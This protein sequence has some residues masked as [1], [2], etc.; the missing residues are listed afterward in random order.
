MN[1]GPTLAVG[2]TGAD[3][4]RLQR[5][6][7]MTKL[8]EYTG[9]DGGFGP[10]TELAVKSFQ[11]ANGLT[12]D[13]VVGPLT[14]RALPADPDTPELGRGATGA[15]VSALQRAL[16]RYGGSGSTTDPG[17]IDGDFGSRT[18]AAVR[19]YQAQRR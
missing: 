11:Q 14:W 10:K 9:I 15:P 19:A 6:L 2:S 17:P 3:V 18:E 5:I 16:L 8:L 7:T 4:P 12:V 1:S 13:G